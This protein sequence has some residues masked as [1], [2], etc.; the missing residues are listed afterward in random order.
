MYVNKKKIVNNK[1]VKESENLQNY[2]FEEMEKNEKVRK[3]V[4]EWEGF[5]LCVPGDWA[6]SA[7]DRCQ[8]FEHDCHK[9]LLEYAYTHQDLSLISEDLEILGKE[10]DEKDFDSNISICL[11]KL[12][13]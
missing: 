5:D 13:C 6:S 11:E 10:L 9:C 3:L 2:N 1:D 12:N 7:A 4:E 8:K